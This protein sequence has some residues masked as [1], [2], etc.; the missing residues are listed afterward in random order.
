MYLTVFVLYCL[1]LLSLTIL[2][3]QPL[4]C[5]RDI[6]KLLLL[7]L[8]LLLLHSR[9]KEFNAESITMKTVQSSRGYQGH[10]LQ[11]PGDKPVAQT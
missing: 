1:L 6:N 7:L 11:F 3:I 4:G 5:E 8:L 9:S 10:W 2:V